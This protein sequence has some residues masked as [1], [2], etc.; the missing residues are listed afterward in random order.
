[1]AVLITGAAGF[2]GTN[3]INYFLSTNQRVFGIDN[4]SRGSIAN[5]KKFLKK[6]KFKFANIDLNNLDETKHQLAHFVR[7]EEI[8]EVWHLA[9]NSDVQAGALDPQLDLENTFLTTFNT[10]KLM[11][12]FEIDTLVFASSSAIYGDIRNERLSENSGPL[13]PISNY[14]AMKLASEAIISASVE[15]F[16]KKAYILRFPNVV[17]TP[18]THGVIYDFLKKLE[19]NPRCLSVLG[20]GNQRK[21][22]LHINDLVS[23]MVFIRER[24]VDKLNIFNVGAEDDGVTVSFIA[25]QVISHVSEY[26][27]IRYGNTDK[28]WIGDVPKFSYSVDKLKKLGWKPQCDSREAVIR[29]IREI[30]HNNHF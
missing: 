10:L 25:K 6:S 8:S 3:L 18:A 24:A 16:L 15:S 22:Y 4:L 21:S 19:R 5:I 12:E 20:N 2:V 28:G 9:A 7:H 1:M 13:L 30:L 26:A 27:Q 17:G 14:G 23:A 11:R 29:A